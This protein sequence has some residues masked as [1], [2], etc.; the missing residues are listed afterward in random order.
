MPKNL[1]PSISASSSRHKGR[2]Y[3]VDPSGKRL[4]SVSTILNA[5]K[6]LED[7]QALRQWQQRI[8]Y[9]EAKRIS[10]QASRRGTQTHA[11][12]RKYLLGQADECPDA[13]K[14]YWTSL[15]PVLQHLDNVRLV[16]GAVFHYDLRYAG[17]IDCIASYQGVPCIIDWKTSD[18]PKQTIQRLYDNPLQLA[19]YCG[20]A[21]HVY[22]DHDIH[23]K[24]AV[25]INAVPDQDAEVFWFDA[26]TLKDYW[27]QWTSRLHQFYAL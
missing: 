13:A 8:G 25:L 19:A 12:L 18:R 7:R 14:P 5:T 6:S 27:H 17:R 11:H 16:E 4:P 21:N 26:E 3:L 20:A 9:T 23:L 1:L 22:S 15:E 10:G 2:S 24:E